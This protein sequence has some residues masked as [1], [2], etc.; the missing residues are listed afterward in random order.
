[1][2]VAMEV[3]VVV[4]VAVAVAVV[5]KAA[6]ELVVAPVAKVAMADPSQLPPT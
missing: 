5:M 6:K 2:A 3:A 1:M 4:A